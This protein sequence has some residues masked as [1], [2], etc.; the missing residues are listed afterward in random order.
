MAGILALFSL[1]QDNEPGHGQHHQSADGSAQVGLHPLDAHL[2]QNGGEAG[3]H[4]GESGPEEPAPSLGGRRIGGHRLPLQHQVGACQ[5]ESHAHRLGE[6]NGFVE[7]EKGQEHGQHG[8]GFVDGSHLIHRADLEGAEVADPGSAGGKAGEDEKEPGSGLHIPDGALRARQKDHDPGKESHHY[9]A[10]GSGQMGV[11]VFDADLRQH[12]GESGK[13][14]GG[15]GMDDPHNGNTILSTRLYAIPGMPVQ[16]KPKRG[17]GKLVF[18]MGRL[19]Q[20][21]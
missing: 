15:K 7:E 4:G 18:L 14:G 16:K 21:V 1:G 9:G 5:H 20:S 13:E 8:A 11:D 3:K 6:G 19:T 2:A 12:G 17:P 10:Q